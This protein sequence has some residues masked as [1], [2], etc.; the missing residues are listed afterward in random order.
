MPGSDPT[1]VCRNTLVKVAQRRNR[2]ADRLERGPDPQRR[3]KPHMD[4]AGLPR[5]CRPKKKAPTDM[6]PLTKRQR[7]WLD[8]ITAADAAAYARASGI[9]PYAYLKTLFAELPAVGTV[10]EVET[11]LQFA[12]TNP[13]RVAA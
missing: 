4:I 1:C 3:T 5:R 11:L 12:R 7:Y 8:Q 13:E 10:E 6:G 2:E 9:E